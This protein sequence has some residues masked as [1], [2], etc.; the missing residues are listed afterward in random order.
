MSVLTN[1]P[2]LVSTEETTERRHWLQVW[3][4]TGACILSLACVTAY[5]FD[6]YWL[7]AADRPYSP[8]HVKLRPSGVLGVKLG[9]AGVVFFLLLFLYP[10]RKKIPWLARRGTAKH[11][12]DFHIVLG[13]TAPALIAFHASFKFH[14]IAG[15]AFWIMLMVALSGLV[16]RYLYAQ[17]PRSINTAE[18]SLRELAEQENE[19]TGILAG[20]NVLTI[21]ALEPFL[22]AP[23]PDE[24]KRMPAL[25]ALLVMMML[26]LSLPFRIAR[27]RRSFLGPMGKL[28]SLGGLL[29]TGNRKLEDVVRT[30]RRKASL[31]KRIAFLAQT[32]HVLH[33]WHVIHRPFSYSF[34]VLAVIHI[35]VAMGLGFM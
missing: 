17:V 1:V 35:A 26:D 19:L 29:S 13:M 25:R 9:I 30:A 4:V 31:S 3:L 5:G 11:W 21:S 15:M 23:S 6:Y 33:L 27:L 7:S 28:A 20:Q 8:K 34:A 22:H 32:Q 14:G 12:L 16:G 2:N 24:V 18:L 10:L